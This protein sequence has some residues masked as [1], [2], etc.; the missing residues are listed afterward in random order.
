MG[1]A[2]K[3]WPAGEE[4]PYCVVVCRS[5]QQG[6][7]RAHQAALQARAGKAGDVFL[8][9]IVVVADAPG[10]TPKQLE[11]KIRVIEEHFRVW[12]VPYIEDFRLSETEALAEW[13]PGM[14]LAE[15]SRTKLGKKKSLTATQA[16][17]PP[18]VTVAEELFASALEAYE[19]AQ[20][21]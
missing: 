21:G 11:R 13:R 14:E 7:E 20:Q 5:T 2:G 19:M 4:N 17:P 3:V 18:V 15:S 10:K 1:D 12:T 16:P 8:I 9:G 6:L